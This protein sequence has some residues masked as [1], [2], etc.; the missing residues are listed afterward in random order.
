MLTESEQGTSEIGLWV[1]EFVLFARG[2]RGTGLDA[3]S[4]LS[5]LSFH[6]VEVLKVQG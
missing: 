5:R 1:W 6:D 3:G 4:R 2:L